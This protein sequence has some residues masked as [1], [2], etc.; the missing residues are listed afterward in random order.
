MAKTQKKI[1]LTGIG[2]RLGRLVAKRLHRRGTHQVIGLD[3][4]T[5]GN[6]PKDIDHLQVDLRS[7]R[8][9]DVFRSGVVDAFI[10]MG[11]KHDPRA[12]PQELHSWN[13]QGTTRLL[14]YC[15]DFNVRKVVFLSSANVYGP[16]PDNSQ[17][18]TEDAPLMASLDF[19]E[20]R[21]LIEADMAATSFFWRARSRDVETVI[22]RPV[23]ILGSVRNAASNYLRLKRIPVMMGFDPMVQVIHEE[24]V[25]DA[26]L[27]ALESGIHG[28][29][30]V[31]GPGEYPLSV[32]VQETGR[33]I[34]PIPHAMAKSLLSRLWK[35]HLTSFP[36]P[37][38]VHI[39]YTCM[40][41]GERAR[42]TMGF[43]PRYSLKET[44]RTVL[45]TADG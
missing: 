42:R 5:L 43:R 27:M 19:P 15:A 39:M 32:V 12:S 6:L 9:R 35:Y 14:E 4:R 34:L 20:I 18:L 1:I 17:F 23:H 8:A 33:P 25:A 24:D 11:L 7:R 28:V 21:D 41:D 16:R 10:H 40:V 36:V 30:N 38:L 45:A 13:V 37:E 31:T 22:L 2:G 29:L 44:I 26:I 3:R